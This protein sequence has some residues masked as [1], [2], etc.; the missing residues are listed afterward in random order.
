MEK[1]YTLFTR[2]RTSSYPNLSEHS[3]KRS[4]FLKDFLDFQP[5]NYEIELDFTPETLFT[6]G[7]FLRYG[8]LDSMVSNY[9]HVIVAFDFLLINEYIAKF[10]PLF[11]QINE[12][13]II[14]PEALLKFLDMEI[15]IPENF[16]TEY[17]SK[18][19]KLL[20]AR[21]RKYFFT[22][23]KMIP[24]DV[25]IQTFINPTFAQWNKIEMNQFI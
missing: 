11:A 8:F 19:G 10:G 25:E 18:L 1:T 9:G 14:S 23:L 15:D 2:D 4:P 7:Q 6:V 5:D 24:T 3:I 17:R 21:G 13:P 20:I 12:S 16:P 22:F